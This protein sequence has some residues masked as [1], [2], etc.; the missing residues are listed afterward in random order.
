MTTPPLTPWQWL[1]LF[2]ASASIA[3]AIVTVV[4]WVTRNA[5]EWMFKD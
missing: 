2:A 4:D 5:P 1:Q 3:V